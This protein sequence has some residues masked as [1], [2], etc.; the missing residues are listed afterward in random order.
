MS[1]SPGGDLEPGHGPMRNTLFSLI[2]RGLSAVFT[3]ALMLFLVRAL[4]PTKYGVLALAVSIGAILML[5]SDLGITL[6]SSRFAAESPRDRMHAAAVLRTAFG[7]KLIASLVA[8]VAL[9]LLAPL[10]ADSFGAPALTLPLRLIAIAMTAQGFGGLICAWFTA[11][12]RVSL[13]LGYTLVES[14]FET[15]A[16]ICIVLLGGGAAGAVAGRAIGYTVSAIL[17][18]ALAVRVVGWPALRKGGKGFPARQIAAY[19]VALLIIDGAFA[20][21]DRVDVLIIG[22]MLSSTSAGTFEAAF[23]IITFL[24]YPALAVGAGFTPRLAA[25]QRTEAETGRFMGALRYMILLY[26]LLAAPLLVWATPIVGLFLGAGYSGSAAVVR[27]MAPTVVVAGLAPVLAGA[28]NFLGEARRRVPLAIGALLVNVIIDLILV[29]RIGIVAGAIGTGAAFA[30]YTGGHV[31]I[32]QRGMGVSFAGLLPT[33]LRG[34]IA[35]GAAALVLLAFGTSH[36]GVLDWIA[37]TV[38]A[39]GAFIG[40]LILVRELR[41]HDARL[42]IRLLSV[43]F[44]RLRERE[45]P[46]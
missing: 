37:G 44:R 13:Q 2:S 16:S 19:G 17:A 35:F 9:V 46:V 5:V 10:I 6:S 8:A 24:Y 20:I 27:A 30:L 43:S 45:A 3:V 21:F 1:G 41:P 33:A 22:A 34:T 42:A 7:L 18:A 32:C 23:R 38:L 36:L 12:G 40:V 26:L 11:L 4:G 39:T 28:A 31:R 29:P 25:G 15:T 14:S